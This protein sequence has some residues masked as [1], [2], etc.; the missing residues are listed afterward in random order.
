MSTWLANLTHHAARRAA[1]DRPGGS[2]SN[3]GDGK[4]PGRFETNVSPLLALARA[5]GATP[6][7]VW[8]ANL[9]HRAMHRAASDRSGGS[10]NR[11]NDGEITGRLET[12]VS[13]SLAPAAAAGSPH[14]AATPYLM[15]HPQQLSLENLHELSLW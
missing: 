5:P 9:T 11:D 2:E 7:A 10:E 15:C 12:D 1:S 13:P 4:I 8:S 3:N 14:V 6:A